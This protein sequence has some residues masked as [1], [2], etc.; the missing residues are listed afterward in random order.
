MLGRPQFDEFLTALG[1]CGSF[2]YAE[3]G[4]SVAQ[5]VEVRTGHSNDSS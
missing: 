4:M 1:M 5:R 2:K 3:S